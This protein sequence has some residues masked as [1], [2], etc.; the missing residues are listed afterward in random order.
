MSFPIVYTTIAFAFVAD[1]I[2][3]VRAIRQTREELGESGIPL[4]RYLRESKDPRIKM[5][6]AEDTAAVTGLLIALV[7]TA[8]AQITGNQAFDAGAAILVGLLLVNVAIAI[9]RDTKGLLIG[10]GSTREERERLRQ[11]IVGRPEIEEVV[12]L[13]T[14]YLGPRPL[15]VAAHVD[16][17]DGLTSE[18]IEEASDA[19][20]RELR[21]AVATVDQV[22][23]DPTRSRG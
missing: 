7:G 23:L 12:D 1:V 9:G 8:L 2:S 3:W 18:Q 21:E 13:R 11:A 22:F 5:V 16:F 20:D 19:L 14:M 17:A 4:V 10:E 6:V 15:L